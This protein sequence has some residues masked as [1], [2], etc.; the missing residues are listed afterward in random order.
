M[1]SYWKT[2][3]SFNFRWPHADLCVCVPHLQWL[4]LC[5][6][7]A[8]PILHRQSSKLCFLF[9]LVYLISFFLIFILHFEF[10]KDY[11]LKTTDIGFCKPSLS[12]AASATISSN[13]TTTTY[14][15]KPY[16]SH[17]QLRR[18]R[19]KSGMVEEQIFDKLNK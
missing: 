12:S 4:W 7:I 18:Q 9:I 11:I 14:G 2:S 17:T 15:I 8:C 3:L 6:N 1:E 19:R 13:A 5:V 16:H 10:L